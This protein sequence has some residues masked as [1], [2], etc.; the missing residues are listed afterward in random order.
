MPAG[1]VRP[2]VVGNLV[3]RQPGGRQDLLGD[4][5][6]FGGGLVSR[7]LDPPL[8]KFGPGLDGQL[9]D[10]EMAPGEGDGFRQ[11]PPPVIGRLAGKRIDE[12]EG[13]PGDGAPGRL[14]GAP[15]L[16]RLVP[17]AEERQRRVVEGLDADGEAVDA[18]IG[19]GGEQGGFRG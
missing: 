6:E 9:I 3:G 13:K 8:V 18:G 17:A 11:L 14:D 19:E 2:G 1:V 16:I 15:G 5:V 7:A 4:L 10:R 12:I